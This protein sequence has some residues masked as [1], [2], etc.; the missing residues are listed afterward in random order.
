MKR[1][2]TSMAAALV[3]LAG[4]GLAGAADTKDAVTLKGKLECSKCELHETADCGN[5]LAV[6][7]GTKEVKYYLVDNPLSL[8]EHKNICKAPK[9]GVTVTGTVADKDGKMWL[10]ATKIDIP[11]G[12]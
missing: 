4:A 7:E 9:D 10:T 5:V 1:H 3:L 8:G 6:K 12:K 11:A 2:L